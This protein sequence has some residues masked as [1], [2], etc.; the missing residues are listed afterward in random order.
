MMSVLPTR[1]PNNQIAGQKL[2]SPSGLVI[3]TAGRGF[4]INYLYENVIFGFQ[5]PPGF[6]FAVAGITSKVLPSK[7][8][9][10]SRLPSLV[11][12]GIVIFS[13]KEFNTV[14]DKR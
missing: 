7:K 3:F 6:Q 13:G 1:L 2:K 4:L 10:V 8:E 14:L 5:L 11:S 9:I 12:G